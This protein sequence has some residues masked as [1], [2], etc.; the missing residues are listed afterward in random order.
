MGKSN[1]I[2]LKQ[3]ERKMEWHHG[4]KS[5]TIGG[6]LLAFFATVQLEDIQKTIVLA[7][8]GAVVS[9]GVSLLL[10]QLLRKWRR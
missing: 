5:G 9:F 1:W 6:T 7:A 2:Q 10:K 8:L 3:K 4:T